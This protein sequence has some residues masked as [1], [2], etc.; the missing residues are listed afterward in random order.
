MVCPITE[1]H[2]IGTING[3]IFFQ[4]NLLFPFNF[5][6]SVKFF[7]QN[8]FA[9]KFGVGVVVRVGLTR[10][11]VPGRVPSNH[12]DKD[13][14]QKNNVHLSKTT[15]T[16]K[17]IE[18]NSANFFVKMFYCLCKVNVIVQFAGQNQKRLQKILFL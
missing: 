1:S 3:F 7:L 4:S 14:D 9:S 13:S 8:V 10:R 12:R 18:I 5:R 16:K 15:T 6:E 17:Q 11:S 2:Q